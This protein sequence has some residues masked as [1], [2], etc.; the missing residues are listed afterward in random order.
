MFESGATSVAY[1]SPDR[2]PGS[3]ETGEAIS[4]RDGSTALGDGL[5]LGK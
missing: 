1:L 3:Q 5:A 2:G 4:G